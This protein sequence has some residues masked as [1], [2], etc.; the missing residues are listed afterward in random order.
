MS[1]I[2]EMLKVANNY[3]SMN[4]IEKIEHFV[5]YL[6]ITP[7]IIHDFDETLDTL[8]DSQNRPI[9]VILIQIADETISK[10]NK[11]TINVA[12]L[13]NKMNTVQ[14]RNRKFVSLFDISP[15]ATNMQIRNLMTQ[16]RAKIFIDLEN[17]FNRYRF[18]LATSILA[19]DSSVEMISYRHSDSLQPKL[20]LDRSWLNLFQKESDIHPDK[21]RPRL[22]TALD[23]LKWRFKSQFNNIPYCCEYG[24]FLEKA[25]YYNERSGWKQI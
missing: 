6:H 7:W 16:I 20:S 22:F 24:G 15:T 1:S 23:S 17:Y 11:D 18:E 3:A 12:S 13:L 9:I 19:N 21:V 25:W 8:K 5:L 10:Y 14:N 2:L 4:K